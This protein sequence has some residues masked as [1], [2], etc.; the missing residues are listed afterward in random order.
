[1]LWIWRNWSCKSKLPKL[2][3]SDEKKSKK[4]YKKKAYIAWEDNA[5]SLSSSGGSDE[6]EA[7]FCLMA[8]NDHSDS[9]VSSSDNEN[10]YDSLHDDFQV[11]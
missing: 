9:E 1:M 4:Y 7:N 6:E 3:R 11:N 10:D 5:S 2:K 8:N